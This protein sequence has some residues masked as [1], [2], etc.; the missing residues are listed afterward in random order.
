[1]SIYIYIYICIYICTKVGPEE[2][3]A[4]TSDAQVVSAPA[5]LLGIADGLQ[6]VPCE[7]GKVDGTNHTTHTTRSPTDMR[8]VPWAAYKDKERLLP[9]GAW[10]SILLKW[11]VRS[12]ELMDVWFD[13]IAL[14]STRSLMNKCISVPHTHYRSLGEII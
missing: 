11:N 1:M 4:K 7:F 14:N 3:A 5:Q 10:S 6:P 2:D 9:R 13:S 12:A 8:V